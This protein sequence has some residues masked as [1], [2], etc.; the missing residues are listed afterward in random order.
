MRDSRY[1]RIQHCLKKETV[2]MGTRTAASAGGRGEGK[3]YPGYEGGATRDSL[4]IE[5]R[6]KASGFCPVD[7]RN[8]LVMVV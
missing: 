8:P 3:V 7:L 1:N 2:L 4:S 5:A 6:S